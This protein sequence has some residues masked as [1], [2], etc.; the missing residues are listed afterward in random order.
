MTTDGEMASFILHNRSTSCVGI[1][2]SSGPEDFSSSTPPCIVGVE[3]GSMK[4][5]SSQL[6]A[7]KGDFSSSTASAIQSILTLMTERTSR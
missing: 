3:G 4:V 7:N 6:Q 2:V 5:A 1:I